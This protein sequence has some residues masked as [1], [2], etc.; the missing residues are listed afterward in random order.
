[1]KLKYFSSLMRD[2]PNTISDELRKH[3][4][5]FTYLLIFIRIADRMCDRKESISDFF[6]NGATPASASKRCIRPIFISFIQRSLARGLTKIIQ[7]EATKK[8]SKTPPN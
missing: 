6:Q 8:V 5:F 1:M 3:V 7:P 2:I 4:P